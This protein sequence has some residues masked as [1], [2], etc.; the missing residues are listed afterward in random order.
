MTCYLII[1]G[2]LDIPWRQSIVLGAVDDRFGNTIV[3]SASIPF[4]TMAFSIFNII[5][6]AV[7]VNIF[8]VYIGQIRNMYGFKKYINLTCGH[9]PFFFH[10]VIFRVLALSFFLVYLDF[11]ALIPIF[12]ILICNLIIG[13]LTSAEH[14]IPKIVRKDL[15]RVKKNQKEIEDHPTLQA[16]GA[17][18]TKTNTSVWLNSF[19]GICVPT[20]FVQDVDPVLLLDMTEQNQQAVF[21]S[22]KN[23]QRRVIRYQIQTSV[24]II[25]VTLLSVF[26]LVNFK[27]DFRYSPN[28][29]HNLD[30]NIYCSVI[31]AMGIT[32]FFFIK[33]IDVYEAF[34]MNEDPGLIENILV[35]V[36]TPQQEDETDN[37]IIQIEVPDDAEI[38]FQ[39]EQKIQKKYGT[40][41]KLLVTVFITVLTMVPLI[42]GSLMSSFLSNPPAYILT[43]NSTPSELTITAV[44]SKVLNNPEKWGKFNGK[45]KFCSSGSNDFEVECQQALN[46]KTTEDLILV[47]DLADTDCVKEMKKSIEDETF[48]CLPYKG[49]VLLE[50]WYNRSSLPYPLDVPSDLTQFPIVSVNSKDT[51]TVF[52]ESFLLNSQITMEISLKDYEDILKDPSSEL[53][54]TDCERSDCLHMF[55]AKGKY[56]G[57][58][59][60]PKMNVPIKLE[61]YDKGKTCAELITFNKNLKH[62]N[63][64]EKCLKQE[65][66]EISKN[67]TDYP[68]PSCHIP[69][70][71]WLDAD[72]CTDS[73]K[74]RNFNWKEMEPSS[75]CWDE[76]DST[77]ITHSQ[78]A[79]TKCD[80]NWG[81]WS[82]WDDN[83]NSWGGRKERYRL[84]KAKLCVLIKR[85]LLMYSSTTEK[86]TEKPTHDSKFDK[87]QFLY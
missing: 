43:K 34:K 72:K 67:R 57:C 32:A 1:V 47:V 41:K 9:F 58:Q 12:A 70:N 3:P 16:K 74:E 7:Q 63:P 24:T 37:K 56:L 27:E 6:S 11:L 66:I 76:S 45:I 82:S 22:Q 51:G 81:K 80:C 65:G 86:C 54:E 39:T 50:N 2:L 62:K 44:K 10:S 42:A 28:R 18:G 73:E 35:T 69:D 17:G 26:C 53:Y 31:C 14:K 85:D 19:L 5:G 59:G 25:L 60:V 55:E 21:K 83:C 46:Q 40:F 84:C 49:M 48:R 78:P 52:T 79:S 15:R 77:I 29:F 8:N 33:E 68:R 4:W 75:S 87:C 30:F 38:S 20:C 36:K 13:Y 61:C 23:Y 71:M 64:F